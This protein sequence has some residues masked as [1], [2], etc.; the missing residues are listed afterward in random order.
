[1]KES[2]RLGELQV[3][4]N[5]LHQETQVYA[6]SGGSRYISTGMWNG[7][8][9]FKLACG[10]VNITFTFCA[11]YLPLFCLIQYMD[12]GIGPLFFRV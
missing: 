9:Q 4:F 12:K 8:M 3:S 7:E 2:Y 6:A 5:N 10:T 11:V 1:M